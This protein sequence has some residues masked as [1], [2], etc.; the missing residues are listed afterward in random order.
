M[1][2]NTTTTTPVCF[3]GL[4]PKDLNLT[5]LEANTGQ[6]QRTRVACEAAARLN[7]SSITANDVV[8]ENFTVGNLLLLPP[9][10]AGMFTFA[11]AQTITTPNTWELSTL[12]LSEIASSSTVG[13]AGP[14]ISVGQDGT[15]LVSV[16]VQGSVNAGT[17]N[18]GIAVDGANPTFT[19]ITGISTT[20]ATVNNS[21]EISLSSGQT[22]QLAFISTGTPTLTV[23]FGRLALAQV[24]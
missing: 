13:F 11:G 12:N 15:Y 17:L 6:L 9:I 19:L 24:Q 5:S 3:S 2:V 21:T 10:P 16:N 1:S 8:A 23:T 20:A 18:V 7:T 22:I 14:A 4:V